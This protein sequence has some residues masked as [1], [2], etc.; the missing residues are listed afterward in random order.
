MAITKLLSITT[1]V[2]N[3]IK[4]IG[5]AEK[6]GSAALLSSYNCST[7]RADFDFDCTASLAKQTPYTSNSGKRNILAYHLV[8]SFSPNDNITPEEAHEIGKQLADQ[9]L[10]GRYEYV[11]AT[12]TDKKNIHNHIIF[13]SVSFMNFQKFA[14][15]PFKTAQRIRSISDRLCVEHG[16]SVIQNPQKLGYSYAEWMARRNNTSWR[17]EL[18]KRIKFAL[19]RST[20]YDDFLQKCATLDVAVNDNGKHI[21]YMLRDLP[22]ERWCRGKNLSDDETFILSSIKERVADNAER[23]RVLTDALTR[24]IP[25]AANWTDLQLRLY[26]EDGITIRSGK[27]GLFFVFPDGVKRRS[28]DFG[29]D[30]SEERLKEAVKHERFEVSDAAA[31]V[32]REWEDGKNSL[33]HGAEFIPIELP[34]DA[35]QKISLDGLLVRVPSAD[36]NDVVFIDNA[37]TDYEPETGHYTIW[38]APPY[39]Y[40]CVPETLDPDVLESEQL[41]GTPY[42]GMDLIKRMERA[43]DAPCEW[44]DVPAD[45]VRS[46]S[47][48]GLILSVPDLGASYIHIEPQDFELTNMGCRVRIFPHWSY[49]RNLYGSELIAAAEQQRNTPV[50]D[51]LWVKYRS[52]QRRSQKAELDILSNALWTME[53]EE[54][55]DRADFSQRAKELDAEIK[56]NRQLI[57]TLVDE[58]DE[59][60]RAVACL[61][62]L[63]EY[64]ELYEEWQRATPGQKLVMEQKN[65]C[66]LQLYERAAAQ[67][68]GMG[69]HPNADPDKLTDY[70]EFNRS[71]IEERRQKIKKLEERLYGIYRAER[72]VND[73][74]EPPSLKKAADQLRRGTSYTL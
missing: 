48:K 5:K 38:L 41:G 12:H 62:V 1:R 13:N 34:P 43:W 24:Q 45:L 3:R 39:Q 6:I 25:N 56:E 64:E 72:V 32:R 33:T 4:Y 40:Y 71:E 31:D 35:V 47:D 74:L 15:Q 18:R 7:D 42:R 51:L 50:I 46:A 57:H 49:A 58:C 53:R 37:H 61:N 14:T 44:I 66:K 2:D 59:Y 17:A 63:S 69:I 54:I 22:Q 65:L 9:L 67:L 11:I 60:T 36:G 8:Q 21:K 10:G 26:R 52:Y 23:K 70:I 30:F 27:S 20:S 68:K 29:F 73:T 28:S 55:S 19:A 16:L